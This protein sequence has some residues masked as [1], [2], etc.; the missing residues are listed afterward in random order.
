V[1]SFLNVGRQVLVRD[2]VDGLVVGWLEKV[3]GGF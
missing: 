3:F 2:T 1:S